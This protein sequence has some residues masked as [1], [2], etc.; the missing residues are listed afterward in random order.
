[1]LS[2]RPTSS[3][4]ARRRGSRCSTARGSH[5]RDAREVDGA[6]ARRATVV[7]ES[8]AS[9]LREAGDVVM[10]IAEGA[11]R[12]E[13]LVMLADVVRAGVTAT[14]PRLFKSTGM[15]WEDAVVAAAVVRSVG[16]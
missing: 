6:L 12:A 3:A 2:R 14:G 8:R 5:E 7:V 16:A 11:L 9:A 1:M 4:A 13:R 15:A 10:A